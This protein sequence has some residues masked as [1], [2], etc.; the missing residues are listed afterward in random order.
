MSTSLTR[1]ATSQSS[2]YP[3]VLTRLGRPRSRSNPHLK[4]WKCRE[5]KTRLLGPYSDTLT[6]RQT[7]PKTKENLNFCEN[8]PIS[9]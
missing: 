5:S 4:L 9:T 7:K 3:I 2:S 1:P 8:L 6:P